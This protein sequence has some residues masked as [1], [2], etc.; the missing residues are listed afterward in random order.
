MHIPCFFLT[1]NSLE[2]KCLE[3][4]IVTWYFLQALCLYLI[5]GSLNTSMAGS[6]KRQRRDNF[7]QSSLAGPKPGYS[8]YKLTVLH[9][10]TQS[11]PCITA[12]FDV[13]AWW[14]FFLMLGPMLII[15]ASA[16]KSYTFLHFVLRA[17]RPAWW[18][19]LLIPRRSEGSGGCSRWP[20]SW[21]SSVPWPYT[22]GPTM[23]TH[24]PW[25]IRI[26]LKYMHS[27][28]RNII[29]SVHIDIYNDIQ[30]KWSHPKLMWQRWKI[31]DLL[32]EMRKYTK[33]TWKSNHTQRVVFCV[34]LIEGF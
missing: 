9:P 28:H 3:R 7:Q 34:I 24:R 10:S 25:V 1:N 6:E 14:L 32:Y 19:S 31:F 26:Y 27:T 22:S 33:W 30:I 21:E 20:L 12:C 4:N 11:N 13:T 18:W 17:P 2:Q 15:K 16:K 29:W 5:T 8:D 23:P